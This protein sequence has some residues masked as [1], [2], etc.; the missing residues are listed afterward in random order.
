[1]G[2]LLPFALCCLAAGQPAQDTGR[3][4]LAPEAL[5]ARTPPVEAWS[6]IAFSTSEYFEETERAGV[7][8]R[9]KERRRLALVTIGVDIAWYL[10][11][12]LSPLGPRLREACLRAAQRLARHRPFSLGTACRV[13]SLPRR[14]FGDDWAGA[15]LFAWAYFGLGALVTLPLALWGE[16]MDQAAGLSNYDGRTWAW[17][18]TKQAAIQLVLF[19]CL[20][21]GLYGL[22]RRLPRYWWLAIGLPAGLAL[23]GYGLIEPRLT[24]IYDKVTPLE[25]SQD[26]A[27]R[28]LLPR[29]EALARAEGV[30]LS[31]VKV[32]HASRTTRSLDAQLLG[33]GA[34]RELL[35]WDNLLEEASPREVEV[36]VAHELGHE[37]QRQDLLTYGGSA[38]GLIVLLWLLS[39]VLRLA[40]R[41]KK[42][43][44]PGDVATWPM[45]GFALFLFFHALQPA[46]AWRKRA[47]ERQADRRALVLTADPE[48]FSRLQMRLAVR[49]QQELR[50]PRWV[51]LLW[52]T[53]PP[54]AERMATA[55]WYASWLRQAGYAVPAAPE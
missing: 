29:L 17:D 4:S 12:L 21:L 26:P 20:L 24:R 43:S 31:S 48:A 37:H 27:H 49:N 47:H 1:M 51:Y 46:I 25:S 45:L 22:V 14:L 9:A 18:A 15:L 23:V 55:R 53:H 52:S 40:G 30:S 13:A 28:A 33:L 35:L 54:P 39:K 32:I 6:T 2:P 19:S 38:L 34:T 10:L 42:M 41:R 7:T 36:A 3:A 50:P 16:S 5:R 44:G 8:R 11:F